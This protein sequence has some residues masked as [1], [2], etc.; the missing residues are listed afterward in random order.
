MMTALTKTTALTVAASPRTAVR[1]PPMSTPPPDTPKTT[2]GRWLT[3]HM[4]THGL[5]NTDVV[6][7]LGGAYDR[8]LISQWKNGHAG[9]SE[10][11]AMRLADAL[12]LPAPD[13]LRHAGYPEMADRI[14]RLAEHGVAPPPRDPVLDMLES[15]GDPALTAPLAADY[16]REMA[17]AKRRVE[18][19]LAEL[20]RRSDPLDPG[21]DTP[22]A[23]TR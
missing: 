13:V 16:L 9:I 6:R 5:R 19:E 11:A 4:K 12:H 18:L 15:V 7:L 17:A 10:L 22:D 23:A 1:T 3:A 14:E 21:D 20:R 8:S 2:F